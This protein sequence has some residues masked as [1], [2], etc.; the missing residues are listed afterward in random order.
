MAEDACC[1][2]DEAGLFLVLIC[3]NYSPSHV[4]SHAHLLSVIKSVTQQSADV[5]ISE[6]EL[7]PRLRRE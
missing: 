3:T 7:S 1:S 2:I 5:D 6:L 4:A